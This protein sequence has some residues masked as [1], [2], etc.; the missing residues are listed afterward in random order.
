MSRNFLNRACHITGFDIR[1]SKEYDNHVP[2]IYFVKKVVVGCLLL[3]GYVGV[4]PKCLALLWR[5]N[6]R[7]LG[8]RT[9]VALV[10]RSAN[11]VKYD[12]ISLNLRCIYW[13]IS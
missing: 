10:C 6:C 3:H 11:L 13:Q 8:F 1:I 9:S 5:T 7:S 2:H 4:K 12:A